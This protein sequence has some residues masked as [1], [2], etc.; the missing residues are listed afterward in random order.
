[1]LAVDQYPRSWAYAGNPIIWHRIHVPASLRS[2]AERGDWEFGI[3]HEIAHDFCAGDDRYPNTTA[4][5]N[6][7]DELF[8]NFRMY[9]AL[10][11]LNGSFVNSGKLYTGTEAKTYYRS[12]GGDSYEKAYFQRCFTP[13]SLMSTLLPMQEVNGLENF[14][15]T[16]RWQHSHEH[17]LGS[18][19]KKFDT[20]LT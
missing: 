8:A 4:H 16:F 9:Y 5:W 1:I 20:F 18:D 10:D 11:Q 7:N 13:D 2:V 12:D 15:Q 17:A 6:W 14:V 3:M 19:R